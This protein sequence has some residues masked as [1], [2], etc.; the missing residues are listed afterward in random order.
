[1][2]SSY[3]IDNTVNT[4]YRTRQIVPN[5]LSIF[6]PFRW[7]AR[8]IKP[9]E[10]IRE[11]AVYVRPLLFTS[12]GPDVFMKAVFINQGI[13]KQSISNTLDPTMLDIAMSPFPVKEE[14]QISWLNCIAWNCQTVLEEQTASPQ[15][16]TEHPFQ[17]LHWKNYS[18]DSTERGY[19]NH[20]KSP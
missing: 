13:P 5:F 9:T 1:M 17:I 18:H 2:P 16:L 19:H 10:Q 3:K 14:I 4:K 11:M 6:Q 12:M 15:F 8:K 20:K 7:T